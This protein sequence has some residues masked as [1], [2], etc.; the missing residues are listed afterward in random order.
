M[1]DIV[2]GS[3]T[4]TVKNE[5]DRGGVKSATLYA[6]I[7]DTIKPSPSRL[8]EELTRLGLCGTL[9]PGHFQFLLERILPDPKSKLLPCSIFSTSEDMHV[10]HSYEVFVARKQFSF[11]RRI[12]ERQTE[13]LR[14]VYIGCLRCNFWSVTCTS[15]IDEPKNNSNIPS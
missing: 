14:I 13:V 12:A 2:G 4:G 1:D 7:L 10:R 6:Y 15:D 9:F 3:P 5:E 11:P 8:W